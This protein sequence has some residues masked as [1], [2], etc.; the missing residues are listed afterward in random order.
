M[1]D[2]RGIEVLYVLFVF[3]LV[4]LT[5][6]GLVDN[7]FIGAMGWLFSALFSCGYRLR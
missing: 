5:L 2:V 1:R 7:P 3:T 6:V 4:L